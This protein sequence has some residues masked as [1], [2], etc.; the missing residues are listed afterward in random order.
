[1]KRL[2][3]IADQVGVSRTTVSNVLHGNTKKVSKEM[4]RKISEILNQ[5]GYV[6][7]T[8]SRELTCKGSCIIGLVLGYN[9]V[10][11]IPSLRDTFV[12]ELLSGVEETAHRNG[13]YV[14]LI[15][16]YD[17][18]TDRVAEIAS[19]W[20][21][22]GLV[23][24]GLDEKKY[25]QLRRQLNKYMVLIDTYPEA[26]Y[27][28]V[29]VGTDD[30]GGG[31]MIAKYLLDNGYTQAIFVA[32]CDTGADH[33]RWKGFQHQMRSAGIDCGGGDESAAVSVA[34]D[35][36]GAYVDTL[37]IT[38][39]RFAEPSAAALFPEG[40]T[41]EDNAYTRYIES[42]LNVDLVD[43]FEAG[44]DAYT[45]QLATCVASGELP[46]ILTV[47][48]YDT[49]VE[50]VNNGLTYD[51]TD[52]YEEY[53]SDYIK[54]LYDSYDGRCLGMATFDGRLMGIPGTNPDNSVPV[55]CWMR[56]DWLDK[57][58]IN[59]DPDGDLCITLDD[60]AAV[61]KA[62]VDAN[63]SGGNH[64]V[65]MAFSGNDIADAMCI[66]NAMGGY[67]DRWIENPDGTMSW[68][69]LAPEVKAAWAKMNE[70]YEEGILDP[71]FGTRTTE[72][73]NAMMINNEL[74]IVFGAWHIPDWRLSSVKALVPE[75]EY[76]AYTVADDNGIV[77]TYHEN[78]A[79][80]FL[81][82]SKDCKYPQVAVEILNILY[83][84]LAR[85][86]AETA[87]DVIAYINAGGHNEGRPYYMEVLPSNNPSIY[88][89]EHMAVINGEMTPEETTIAEN[90]GSSQAILDY[91]KDPQNVTEKTLGGWHF[92]ESR[93]IGLGASIEALE[94][95]GN[96]EWI[97]PKYPP[98]TPTSEQKKATL[99]K[100]E[101]EAYVAIVTGAQ[102][103]DY[104]DT[105]VSEWK[106][107]G[108]DAIA[109]EVQEYFAQ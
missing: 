100:T 32:E 78:A 25:K 102:P 106:R 86:T 49:F 74:G 69:T 9:C 55:L 1:M 58:G 30:F 38:L 18:N 24:L 14:M 84:D 95:N 5:E 50:M 31:A 35:E 93:I 54:S 56:K 52:V 27:H 21:V 67:I 73:I 99:D 75:A 47:N 40:Q 11:G 57:L 22:D 37:T 76:I 61:A 91:L 88:Y 17:Q 109:Q 39:G 26:E 62:F 107:L 98:T 70:W 101:L 104:F 12:A 41:F 80:R 36:N 53:A 2:Q 90:R 60:I 103:I 64:T 72:D 15:N 16:G 68:S 92:Y 7:N 23:V 8:S 82:V 3:D 29:N 94:K 71:Q 81:V 45:N 19:R 4:I 97:T 10:H 87:P 42:K 59:P 51:L 105:F 77:H 20:N 89:T 79:D 48:S 46:D 44:G 28:Y 63:V 34:K 108:G 33:Y 85:A 6:P 65:G 66:A 83:D 96:A 43:S 13:Y